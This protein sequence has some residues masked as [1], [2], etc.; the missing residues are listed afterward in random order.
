L[1][2]WKCQTKYVVVAGNALEFER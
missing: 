2:H 1:N